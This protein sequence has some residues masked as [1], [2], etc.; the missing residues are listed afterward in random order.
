MNEAPP[1]IMP[2][3]RCHTL[4]ACA[5]AAACA[6]LV[7]GRAAALSH[8]PRGASELSGARPSCSSWQVRWFTEQKWE[9]D[10]VP[11][12]V[13][14][15]V[16]QWEHEYVASHLLQAV[17]RRRRPTELLADPPKRGK[18]GKGRGAVSSIP[19]GD[20]EVTPY[21]AKE[22]VPLEDCTILVLRLRGMYGEGCTNATALD[23]QYAARGLRRAYV[24]IGEEER[25]CARC[26]S[27]VESA[28]LVI[29]NYW[30]EDCDA[31]EK[32]GKVLTVPLG[33]RRPSKDARE[34]RDLPPSR[35]P[36]IWAFSSK[37]Q[38]P[39][40]TEMVKRF[41]ERTFV[42]QD[43]SNV[44]VWYPGAL[45]PQLY[46]EW[47]CNA[48]FALV[49]RGHVEDTWRL[50]ESMDCG[51]IPIVTDGGAYFTHFMPQN[52]T[53]RF[54][55]SGNAS[56]MTSRQWDALFAQIDDLL[57]NETALDEHQYALTR[58]FE[59]HTLA[60]QSKVVD[61]LNSVGE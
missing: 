39:D 46:S 56:N 16:P 8:A 35:R 40:R 50:A 45:K 43:S 53:E 19:V 42:G 55:T 23:A 7:P 48:K 38:N 58:A 25:G 9:E 30:H 6:A 36:Y 2:R 57:R 4:G 12:Q 59:A 13:L 17:P 28:P 27:F 1:V 3:Q 54:V 18:V 26:Q 24:L 41:T 37:E 47:L 51:A 21:G 29:R 11:H 52:L 44:K 20:G 10:Y 22:S 34:Q 14:S 60:W 31:Y 61:R 33:I 15:Q 49:P 32:R 5:L